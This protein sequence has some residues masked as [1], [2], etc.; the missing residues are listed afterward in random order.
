MKFN[1]EQREG[2]ARACDT[3]AVTAIVGAVVGATGHSPLQPLEIW[4]LIVVAPLLFAV[5]Y[6]FRR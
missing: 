4:C 6:V 5:G 1:K 3:M 2:F